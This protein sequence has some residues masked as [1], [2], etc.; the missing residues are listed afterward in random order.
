MQLIIALVLLVCA[1][2]VTFAAVRRLELLEAKSGDTLPAAHALLPKVGEPGT[3]TTEHLTLL[4]KAGL[5]QFDLSRLSGQ[6]APILLDAVKYLEDVWEQEFEKDRTELPRAARDKALEWVL[7]HESFIE[8]A[9]V[10][11]EAHDLSND[12]ELPKDTCYWHVA[13]IFRDAT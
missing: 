4:Q 2:I 3:V 9:V 13:S 8:R 1:L 12:E 11:E 6:Q 5:D 7:R 10:F